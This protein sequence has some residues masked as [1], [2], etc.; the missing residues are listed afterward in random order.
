MAIDTPYR[1]EPNTRTTHNSWGEGS[2]IKEYVILRSGGQ[3]LCRVD[4][5]V[6]AYRIVDLLNAEE[7]AQEG[8]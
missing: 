2:S 4:N 3:P 1:V 8:R 5:V 7:H 6:D